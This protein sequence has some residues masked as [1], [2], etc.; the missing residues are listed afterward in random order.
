MHGRAKLW[1]PLKTNANALNWIFDWN[2]STGEICSSQK[3]SWTSWRCDSKDC[4]AP[5]YNTLQ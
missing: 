3:S 5:K 4:E 2:T 1:R